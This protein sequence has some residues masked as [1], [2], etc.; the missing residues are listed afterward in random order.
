ML[1]NKKLDDVDAEEKTPR[2]RRL[3]GKNSAISAK[4][5]KNVAEIDENDGVSVS[6]DGIIVV[7]AEKD[8]N[9]DEIENG[10]VDND[11]N[12]RVQNLFKQTIDKVGK[13]EFGDDAYTKLLAKRKEAIKKRKQK[14]TMDIH[15][16]EEFKGKGGG[17][18][19][20]NG[21]LQPYAYIPLDPKLLK[22][23]ALFLSLCFVFKFNF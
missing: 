1:Q 6:S 19:M 8:T 21:K 4:R 22:K 14:E 10:D 18:A 9:D 20:K 13:Q 11:M 16:G 2:K 12:T 5:V 23:F 7:E 17:D 15:T 3:L